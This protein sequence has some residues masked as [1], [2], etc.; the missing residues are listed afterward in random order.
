MGTHNFIKF[1]IPNCGSCKPLNYG[2]ILNCN[3]PDSNS[4]TDFI[5]QKRSWTSI[6]DAHKCH[7]AKIDVKPSQGTRKKCGY[8]QTQQ[9]TNTYEYDEVNH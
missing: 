4:F 6:T 1:N 7:K 9:D 8:V 3:L 5:N 2:H